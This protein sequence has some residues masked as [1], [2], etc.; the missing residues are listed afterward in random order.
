ML[1]QPEQKSEPKPPSRFKGIVAAAKYLRVHRSHLWR[2]LTSQRTSPALLK[3]YSEYCTASRQEELRLAVSR[4]PSIDMN[5]SPRFPTFKPDRA[6]PSAPGPLDAAAA[7]FSYLQGAEVG[8]NGLTIV[9]LELEKC[10]ATYEATNFILALVEDFNLAKLG[11]LDSSQYQSPKINHFLYAKTK[12][13]PEALKFLRLRLELGG[14]LPISCVAFMD[15]EVKTW[16][17]F[18]PGAD[19][20]PS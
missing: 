8:A 16:R 14:L 4:D 2:C 20:T 19:V 11:Y 10:P 18:Y 12:R 13:L 7:N 3:K 17:Q 5:E 6:N 9:R 1:R 15:I